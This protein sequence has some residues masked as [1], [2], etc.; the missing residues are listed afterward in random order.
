[1]NTALYT[2]IDN[3]TNRFRSGSGNNTSSSVSQMLGTA[4]RERATSRNRS[5]G[6]GAIAEEG[7]QRSGS[8]SRP[9]SANNDLSP[10]AASSS[11]AMKTIQQVAV[12]IVVYRG[13]RTRCDVMGLT[14]N[15]LYHFKMRYVG[16]R[17]NSILSP[18][19]VP[20][21]YTHLTLPTICS[22]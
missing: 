9:Q 12:P 17:S 18:P 13:E 2:A 7:S 1:M 14:P 16:S 8:R 20:V 5:R 4:T 22:V 10:A 3:G 19:L 21:S 11:P 15:R 6:M